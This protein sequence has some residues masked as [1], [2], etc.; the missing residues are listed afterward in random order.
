MHKEIKII[1]F[2][3]DG[4]LYDG[5]SAAFHLAR[6][7]GLG[8]KYEE[9]FVRMAT[10]NLSF[11]DS[12]RLGAKIWEGV[13]FGGEYRELV[14]KLPLMK[15]AEET[16]KVLKSTGYHI[17]CISSGV[18]QFFMEPLMERLNLE[19]AFSNILGISNGTHSGKIEY[20]MGG[21]Q[22]AETALRILKG[23]GL[24][25]KNLASVGNGENDIQLFGVS[26]FS[27]AFNPI[28]ETVSEAATVTIHSKNLDS[29]LEH[30]V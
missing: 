20:A 14:M 4:V 21:P 11:E 10:E 1:S 2:D 22:K 28:S 16:T 6:Q 29:I 25:T 27:I 7:V 9:L 30:F 15:G 19:F 23:K 5:P 24:S 26:G 17:G 13:A 8:K 12:L 18:S 3:L